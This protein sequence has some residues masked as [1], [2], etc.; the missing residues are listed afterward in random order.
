MAWSRTVKRAAA[1]GARPRGS[2]A[3]R[4]GLGE[5]WSGRWVGRGDVVAGAFALGLLVSLDA[6]V[7]DG[8]EGAAV[9]AFAGASGACPVAWR[10][11]VVGPPGEGAAL[12]RSVFVE[13]ADG[14]AASVSE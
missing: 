13:G 7:F 1:E 3:R 6:D 2:K 12:E 5:G 4:S 9:D 10:A 11:E 8:D 14:A